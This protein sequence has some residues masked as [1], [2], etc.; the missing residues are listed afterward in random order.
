MADKSPHPYTAELVR[1]LQNEF[2]SDAY[3]LFFLYITQY[4]LIRIS[5]YN[6]YPSTCTLDN[7]Y[8]KSI[9]F[10]REYFVFNLK[11]ITITSCHTC[12]H[13][14]A[15]LGITPPISFAILLFNDAKHKAALGADF[16]PASIVL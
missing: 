2:I 9:M 8:P 1:S 5:P 6:K 15:C 11:L 12:M 7:L 16:G 3:F 4:I 10:W 14:C 13:A